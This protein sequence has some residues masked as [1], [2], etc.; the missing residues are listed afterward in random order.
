MFIEQKNVVYIA[1][2]K[3]S[4]TC[5]IALCE[6]IIKEGNPKVK[7]AVNLFQGFDGHVARWTPEKAK[8]MGNTWHISN[9]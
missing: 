3:D 9:C 1:R 2:E 6:R 5:T 8:L 4:R 7:G